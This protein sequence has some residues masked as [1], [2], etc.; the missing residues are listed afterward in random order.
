MRGAADRVAEVGIQR[1]LQF[2]ERQAAI[3]KH[4]FLDGVDGVAGI[5]SRTPAGR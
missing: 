5:G 2:L 4:L 3:L 1:A